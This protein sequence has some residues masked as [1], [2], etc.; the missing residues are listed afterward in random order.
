MNI[1][2]YIV[3]VLFIYLL[4]SCNKNNENANIPNIAVNLTIYPNDPSFNKLQTPGGWVYITGGSQGIIVY[5]VSADIFNALDRHSTYKPENNCRVEVDNTQIT[6]V[7]SCSGSQWVITDGGIIKG[8]AS[9]PLKKYACYW[10]GYKLRI[11][12]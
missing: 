6:A 11:T 3:C 4:C 5:R 7:D 8:P 10:D 12:N 9:R 1:F 2:K